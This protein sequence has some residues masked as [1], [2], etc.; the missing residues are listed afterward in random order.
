M[1]KSTIILIAVIAVVGMFG[2]KAMAFFNSEI[3][4]RIN[5]IGMMV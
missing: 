3:K 1:S 5:P 2:A 4:P